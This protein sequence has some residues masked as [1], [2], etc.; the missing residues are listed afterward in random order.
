[1]LS[2]PLEPLLRDHWQTFLIEISKLAPGGLP[3]FKLTNPFYDMATRVY[4]FGMWATF[5]LACA[6]AV[7]K[8]LLPDLELLLI[9]GVLLAGHVTVLGYIC[10]WIAAKRKP[11][12]ASLGNLETLKD[13]CKALAPHVHDAGLAKSDFDSAQ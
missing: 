11:H 1:R 6:A 12:A 2:T 4:G 13:L 5:L 7:A 3:D 10:T 8:R 9:I